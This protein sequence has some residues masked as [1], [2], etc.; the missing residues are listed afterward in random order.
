MLTLSDNTR[1]PHLCLIDKAR[2]LKEKKVLGGLSGLFPNRIISGLPV[3]RQDPPSTVRERLLALTPHVTEVDLIQLSM[4][5]GFLLLR[6]FVSIGQ[7][8]QASL[9]GQKVLC[10]FDAI[11]FL[12]TTHWL[13]AAGEL[14]VPNWS[15]RS[16]GQLP[17]GS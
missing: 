13:G 5:D 12:T 8:G 7:C 14:I 10:R 3:T 15:G 11:I 16:P 2:F 6:T 9:R 1:L 4:I 17:S